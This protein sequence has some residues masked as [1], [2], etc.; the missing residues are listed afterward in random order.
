MLPRGPADCIIQLLPPTFFPSDSSLVGASQ[1]SISFFGRVFHLAVSSMPSPS[2]PPLFLCIVCVLLDKLEAAFLRP[3]VFPYKS[4][5]LQKIPSSGSEHHHGRFICFVAQTGRL[6]HWCLVDC[7]IQ[8][9]ASGPLLT[10]SS[11][12]RT[13]Q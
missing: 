11:R 2:L 13:G 5:Q 8:S 9:T 6:C 10:F 7:F 1:L 3:A 12:E 4:S